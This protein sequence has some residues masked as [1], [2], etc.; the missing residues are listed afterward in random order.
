MLK[1]VDRVQLAVADRRA[2]AQTFASLLGAEN[3]SDDRLDLYN[4]ERTTV[5]AGGSE[6]ELLEPAGPGAVRD[7]IDQWGEGIFAAGF[8]TEDLTA[9]AAHL[10]DAGAAWRQEGQQLFLEPDQTRGMRV[11]L[12]PHR[13]R[14]RVGVVSFL[15]EVTNIV[16]DHKDSA[17]F[18]ADLFGLHS[19]RFAPIKSDHFEYEGTL[20]LFDP[21]SRL[22]R[23]ELTEAGESEAAM[24]R[25]YKKRGESIYMCYMEAP[26]VMALAGRLDDAGARWATGGDREAMNGLFIHPSALHGVLMGISRPTYAWTWSGHPELV[27]PL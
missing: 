26:D 24:G 13:E 18:Y 20:T 1:T 15:Y 22:D 21:P 7:R 4:A 9:L 23:I 17:N 11:V 6:F 3:V 19:S 14:D 12:S 2:A 25:F 16:D 8:S 27:A 10:T 5:Q